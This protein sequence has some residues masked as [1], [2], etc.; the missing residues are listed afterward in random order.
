MKGN[1]P[2]IRVENVSKIYKDGDVSNKVLDNI[3][4]NVNERELVAVVGDSGS[5]KT[6]LMN[7]LGGLD[8][9]DSGKIIIDNQEVSKMNPNQR[10]LYRRNN[11][12]FIFQDYNLIQ[13]LNVYENIMLPLQLSHKEA[14]ENKIDYLLNNLKLN[15]KKYVLPS[16]LS[17]GEQQRVAIIRALI[18]EPKLILADEPTGNLDSKNSALVINLIKV[19]CRKMGRTVIIVTHNIQIAK[20]CDRVI[21]VKDGKIIEEANNE[22]KQN[23]SI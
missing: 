5:G 8:K 4:F 21:C 23:T 16:K 7:L 11:I 12:G 13:V 1:Q 19:L 17:G 18:N 22:K 3:S 6:T 14:D 15:D 10:T 20:L 2:F 9:M